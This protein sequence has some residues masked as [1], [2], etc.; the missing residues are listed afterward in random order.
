MKRI[1]IN[2][3]RVEQ[4]GLAADRS[5]ADQLAGLDKGR[6]FWTQDC[7]VVQQYVYAGFSPSNHLIKRDKI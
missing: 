5:K 4:I 2:N 3:S 1:V 6:I 7:F